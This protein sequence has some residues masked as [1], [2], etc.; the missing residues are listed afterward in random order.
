MRAVAAASVIPSGYNAS[1]AQI[2]SRRFTQP[3]THNG[4]VVLKITSE[5][6]VDTWHE[7]GIDQCTFGMSGNSTAESKP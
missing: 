2:T 4:K 7:L 6:V 5:V 1:V 3:L